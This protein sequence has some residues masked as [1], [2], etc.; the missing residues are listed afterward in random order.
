MWLSALWVRATSTQVGLGM[1]LRPALWGEP[2][3]CDVGYFNRHSDSRALYSSWGVS[4][5]IPIHQTA[6][7][8]NYTPPLT[9]A[10]QGC[11]ASTLPLPWCAVQVLFSSW[12]NWETS[13]NPTGPAHP[14]HQR[15]EGKRKTEEKQPQQL[16]NPFPFPFWW[17]QR[18]LTISK[19]KGKGVSYGVTLGGDLG[20]PWKES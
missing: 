15:E 17:G 7:L 1:G 19:Q 10:S 14:C 4:P 5:S 9:L 12:V 11:T 3:T 2:E 6:A 16:W 20:N 8:S 18:E 13:P